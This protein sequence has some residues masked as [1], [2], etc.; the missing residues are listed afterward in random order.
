[1]PLQQHKVETENK[2][3][4]FSIIPLSNC[5]ENKRKASSIPPYSETKKTIEKEDVIEFLKEF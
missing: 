3:V 2:E 5:Q 4:E 1:M